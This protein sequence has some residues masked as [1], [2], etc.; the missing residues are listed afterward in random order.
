MSSQTHHRAAALVLAVVATLALARAA[1]PPRVVLPPQ[2]A[3]VVAPTPT[4][5]Q[6]SIDPNE[7]DT[8]TLETLPGV[9]PAI[10]RRIVAARAGGRRFRR[11]EELTRVRGIG[12]RTVERI[13]PYLRFAA[14][15]P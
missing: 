15:R 7:A 1:P 8:R 13:A 2:P 14:H 10:A 9:G 12:A 4:P 3:R 6:G 11:A 5:T